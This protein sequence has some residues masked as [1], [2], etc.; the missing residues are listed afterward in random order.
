MAVPTDKLEWVAQW[1]YR[2]SDA[3]HPGDRSECEHCQ[4]MIAAF[5][6]MPPAE[7][8]REWLAAERRLMMTGFKQPIPDS[9]RWEVWERDN[10]TCKHCGSRRYLTID[11]VL[12]ES[13]GGTLALDNLQTLCR[14]CNSKK[15]AQ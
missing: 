4:E 8:I 5:G 13:K 6:P 11:H 14:S 15:G 9:I 12:A 1:A 7:S 10:F 3:H 2:H